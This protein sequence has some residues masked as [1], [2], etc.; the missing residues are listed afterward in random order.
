LYVS[1]GHRGDR[2]DYNVR[3]VSGAFH[4]LRIA[5]GSQWE[6]LPSTSSAQGVPLVAYGN[7]LY[8]IGGMA[9]RNEPGTKQDLFSRAEVLR[10]DPR[11]AVWDELPALPEPRS[12]HDATVVGGKLYVGGGWQLTGGTNKPVW[13]S[14][15]LV[16]D[17]T[18]P[19]AGWKEIPQPFQRRALAAAAIGSRIFFIG[20][21]DS[22]NSPTL[23]VDIYDTKSG[24]WSRGP[25][26]PPGKFK[27]FSCSAV[28]QAD[29]IY[30]NAFQGDLLRLA[31]DE[32]SWEVV[33][34]LDHP[35]MAHR[36]VTAGGT[37]LIALGGED[38]DAKR[39][40]LELLTP[41][42]VGSTPEKGA[43]NPD[44]ATASQ[45]HN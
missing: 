17:L 21:M 13:P 41:A 14:S 42:L 9:A 44:R 35:R 15:L 29:R 30:A 32:R 24:A 43:A 31:P 2:H 6:T 16:L 22:D 26:L 12:S 11:R 36:L 27:G 33:G 7:C 1:G 39:P 25:D 10:Y 4:R 5:G 38:G 3:M 23:A 37:Q 34:R 18:E 8:R 40:D 19:H 28:T 45:V 20:G